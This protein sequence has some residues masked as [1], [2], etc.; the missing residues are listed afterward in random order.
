M[1]RLTYSSKS[2]I[3]TKYKFGQ[4]ILS[5]IKPLSFDLI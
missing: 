1:K 4:K 2:L 5:T 3:L